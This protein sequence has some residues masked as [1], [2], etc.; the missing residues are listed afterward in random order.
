MAIQERNAELID[1]LRSD[2]Q[3]RNEMAFS[4]A[5]AC[6]MYLQLPGLR[7]FWPMSAVDSSGNAQDQSGHSHILTYTGNSVY[8]LDLTTARCLA[9]YIRFDGTG[10][11]LTRA[12][13]ADFDITGT[14]TYFTSQA[15]SAGAA[16]GMTCGGWFRPEDVTNDQGLVTKWGAAGNYSWLLGL[17]GSVAGDPL[18]LYISDDGTNTDSVSSAAA[19]AVNTWQFMA[20][21]FNDGD[22]GAELAVFLNG[23]GTT[24]ATARASIFSGN[25][26]FNI[27]GNNNGTALYTGRAALC[28]Q[29]AAALPNVTL[30][31]LYQQTRT[32]FGV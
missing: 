32:L 15:T 31:A 11:Y 20:G 29:C 3:P 22:A 8:G 12:D 27:S 6:S 10:D 18:R 7:G 26:P 4:W 30:W 24:A 13:E 21:R 1:M 28:F 25:G 17:Y 19:C 23:T 5:E 14:E 9:A 16:R 2:F